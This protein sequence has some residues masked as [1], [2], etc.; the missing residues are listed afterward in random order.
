MLTLRKIENV[1]TGPNNRPKLAV[2]IVGQSNSC[3]WCETTDICDILFI[4]SVVRCKCIVQK[5]WM[6]G[7]MQPFNTFLVIE[8]LTLYLLL[9]VLLYFFSSA[10]CDIAKPWY[11]PASYPPSS[12]LRPALLVSCHPHKLLVQNPTYDILWPN[13]IQSLSYFQAHTFYAGIINCIREGDM[14]IGSK[15]AEISGLSQKV[16]PVST[17]TCG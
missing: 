10:L 12:S 9:L 16:L 5:L 11:L 15:C 2:K 17:W 13:S 14:L 8:V 6:F 4:Q 1:A 3:S 7:L